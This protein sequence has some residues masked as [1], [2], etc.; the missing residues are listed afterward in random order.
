MH[1]P[2]PPLDGTVT[3]RLK[4]DLELIAIKNYPTFPLGST[5]VCSLVLYR[6]HPYFGERVVLLLCMGYSRHMQRRTNGV[7]SYL[8]VGGSRHVT[9]NQSNYFLRGG[10]HLSISWRL[11]I[12]YCVLNVDF[13]SIQSK[14]LSFSLITEVTLQLN[15]SFL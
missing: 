7:R 12:N 13:Q 15:P 2:I 3:D 10:L 8:M 1:R 5:P 11:F 4:L 9:K 14:S 6:R